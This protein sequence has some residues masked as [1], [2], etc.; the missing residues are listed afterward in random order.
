M[1]Y[2]QWI[3]RIWSVFAI[4]LFSLVCKHYRFRERNEIVNEQ[5]IIEEQ[6]E[7]ELLL[8]DESQQLSINH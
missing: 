7:R 8:N 6:Y 5:A 2:L 1:E 3:E 4:I